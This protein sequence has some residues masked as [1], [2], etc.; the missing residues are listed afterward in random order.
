M[1][2][3]FSV[4]A[5]NGML[6]AIETEL[7]ATPVLKL[8][9][10]AQPANCAAANSGTELVSMTLP[11]DA[12]AAASSGTKAKSGTWSGLGIAAG[13]AA[14]FR[15][16]QSNGTTCVEQGTVGAGS[17]DLSLDNA[18]IAIGQTVSVTTYTFTAP[19]A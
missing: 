18:V 14:H 11:A 7:G 9:T 10:G 13:T 8:F 6:D 2:I 19:N 16:Y 15:L 1:A 5:R 12:F 4:N 17:G 3:Q